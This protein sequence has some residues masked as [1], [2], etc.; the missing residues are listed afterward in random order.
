[1]STQKINAGYTQSLNFCVNLHRSRY[2]AFK[3]EVELKSRAAGK[4]ALTLITLLRMC[5]RFH[6][7]IACLLMF[8]KNICNPG[9]VIIWSNI[10]CNEF[11]KK[12]FKKIEFF[13]LIYQLFESC[14]FKV[15]C[16]KF[17]WILLLAPY[18]CLSLC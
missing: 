5:L 9:N 12:I 15:W 11:V 18:F 6:F 3:L 4:M 2:S 10:Y 13:Q 1:M 8:L 7:T 16:E 14:M 17:F